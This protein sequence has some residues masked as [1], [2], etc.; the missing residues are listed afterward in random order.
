ME[1]RQWSNEVQVQFWIIVYDQI[2]RTF[3]HSHAVKRYSVT[4]NSKTI[5]ENQNK[6]IKIKTFNQNFIMFRWTGSIFINTLWEY[7]FPKHFRSS[8][9]FRFPGLFRPN[10]EIIAPRGSPMDRL[11]WFASIVLI[12]CFATKAVRVTQ[13]SKAR[14]FRPP[15]FNVN[16]IRLFVLWSTNSPKIMSQSQSVL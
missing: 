4:F 8:P 6:T 9:F 5:N 2:T 10:F 3:L 13:N 12:Y 7:N 11:W 15:P 14:L 1:K 16:R